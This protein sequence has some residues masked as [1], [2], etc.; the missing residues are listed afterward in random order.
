MTFAVPGDGG[1]L[2]PTVAEG[3]SVRASATTRVPG[4]TVAIMTTIG[5]GVIHAAAAGVHAE[6]PTLARLFILCAVAQ[7]GVG[8]LAMARPSRLVAVPIVVVNAVAVGVWL[9]TR[10]AGISWIDGLEVREA[11][12]FADTACALLAATAVGCA[13]AAAMIGT[14]QATAPRLSF[15]ALAVAALTIPAMLSGSTHV[16]S[17]GSVASASGG[18]V[19]E[20]QPHSHTADGTSATIDPAV[21]PAA[22]AVDESQPHSHPADSTGTVATA[23]AT[24]PRPWDPAKPIDVSGVPGVT[25]EQQARATKLIEDSLKDLPKYADT[26]AAVADGYASIGDAATGDEHYIKLSLI[27]DNDLLDPTQPES[28]VYKVNGESRT[29]AGAMYIASARPTDD[30]S[31]LNWAGPLMQ[32]HNHGNLCWATGPDGKPRVVGITDANGNCANGVNTGGQNPMVHVW[33]T[34][35]PC[36]VFAALEGVG[37]G[38][39]AVPEG[40]R[41]DLCNQPHSHT[42][43]A[44]AAKPYDPTQPIDLGGVPGVTPE[45]QAAAENLVA[46]NVVRLPQWADYQVAEAA[47][48]H[49]IG[50]GLTG[51]E[52][53]IKWDLINDDVSLDPDHPESLVYQPQP[54]GSKKLVSAMYFLPDTVGL[55]DVPNIGGALMQWHIHDNLCFTD[56]PVAPLV[57][58]VTDANGNCGPPFVKLA[59]APMIHVWI[60]PNKC[61]PFAA[62]EGIGAGQIAD[63]ETRLCDSAH[64]SGF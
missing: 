23:T 55:K 14:R 12:Q 48:Y 35:H 11:A 37:A 26:A 9:Q 32:W 18:V 42:A 21:N 10:I 30:P 63:G 4:L 31:L 58:G 19:A 62:L 64:G 15:P 17:H 22:A 57:R 52:H 39:A 45:Q 29:L 7:V 56:D 6:H 24:W 5:A 16:H 1:L 43:A 33:I 53:F 34:P 47:G 40:Q 36:G 59:S 25:A 8:L 46:V 3:P 60:T 38:Q 2:E 61:G 27:E 20:S 44:V 28:L 50:D 54:D 41:I 49:S 51:F 13:L